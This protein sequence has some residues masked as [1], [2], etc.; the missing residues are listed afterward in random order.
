VE[1]VLGD[2]GAAGELMEISVAQASNYLD[3][4]GVPVDSPASPDVSAKSHVGL[5]LVI[6]WRVLER[7]RST[8]SRLEPIGG[9]GDLSS[10]VSDNWSKQIDNR[11]DAEKIVRLLS[12]QS[13][14]ILALRSA[15]YEW[16]DIA[17]LMNVSVASLRSG[18]W[19]EIRRLRRKIEIQKPSAQEGK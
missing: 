16:S 19:H 14:T 10:R 6:F 4:K 18:F 2:S 8:L 5:L 11:L 7:R 3:R 9:I 13:R 17:R 12:E 1:S 15:G